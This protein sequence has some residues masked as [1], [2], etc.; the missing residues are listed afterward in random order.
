MKLGCKCVEL[1]CWDGEH[2]EPVVTHG[3]TMV[4]KITFQEI[5]VAIKEFGFSTSQYPVILSL[6]NH[7][8]VPQQIK[9]TEILKRVLGDMIPPPFTG[10]LPS[11]DALKGKVLIKGKKCKKEGSNLVVEEEEEEDEVDDGEDDSSDEEKDKK[12]KEVKKEKP[13]KVPEKKKKHAHTIAPELSAITHLASA[14]YGGFEK[15]KDLHPWDMSS[16]SELKIK[17]IYKTDSENFVKHNN[18]FLSRTYPKGTRFDSS[19]FNGILSWA[20]GCH[21]VALNYQTGDEYQYINNG[22]FL[23]NGKSGYLLKPQALL[24][25]KQAPPAPVKVT[26]KVVSGWQLP[27]ASGTTKGDVIDPYV[28]VKL[29][30]VGNDTHRSVTKTVNN[31]GFNPVWN[32]TISFTVE[33]PDIAIVLIQV[34]DEDKLSK[35]DFVA[36][37]AIPVANLR[38]GYRSVQ[39]YN[40]KSDVYADSSLLIHVKVN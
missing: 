22:K 7:C 31:N 4:S 17:K 20:L 11:P 21:M 24:P 5:I 36:Q 34:F 12:K 32:E 14:P 37:S 1:D 9:M 35:D 10:G 27:K 3:H 28:K 18:A 38:E 8:S 40:N 29:F 33:R 15:D 6:E 26:L 30:G 19:N 25:A 23:D 2:G 39:L 16:F 13:P